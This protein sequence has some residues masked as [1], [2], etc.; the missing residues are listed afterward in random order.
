MSHIH[1]T[2]HFKQQERNTALIMIYIYIYT[3]KNENE[4]Y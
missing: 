2:V 4:K 1:L 3:I